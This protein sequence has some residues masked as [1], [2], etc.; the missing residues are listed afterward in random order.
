MKYY[1]GKARIVSLQECGIQW[2]CF[3]GG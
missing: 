2:N 1:V 3:S